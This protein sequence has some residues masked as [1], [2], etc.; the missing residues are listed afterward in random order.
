MQKTNALQLWH[1]TLQHSTW[2]FCA[3]SLNLDRDMPAFPSR[4]CHFWTGSL[5]PCEKLTGSDGWVLQT[6]HTNE[7]Y[8]FIGSKHYKRL[9]WWKTWMNQQ[10]QLLQSPLALQSTSNILQTN[11]ISSFATSMIMPSGIG[12]HSNE[13]PCHSVDFAKSRVDFAERH[14]QQFWCDVDIFSGGLLGANRDHMSRRV[15]CCWVWLYDYHL[16]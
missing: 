8:G 4:R 9:A 1:A 12:F 2:K 15:W 10:Q 7:P 6:G 5:N 16:S 3:T 14:S 11:H 13:P